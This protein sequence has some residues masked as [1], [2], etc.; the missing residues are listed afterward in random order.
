MDDENNGVRNN[1][2]TCRCRSDSDKWGSI[3]FDSSCTA[4][5]DNTHGRRHKGRGRAAPA[6]APASWSLQGGRRR[7]AENNR[8]GG[9][10][11]CASLC[12]H[13]QSNSH[14]KVCL[15]LR[16]VSAKRGEVVSLGFLRGGNSLHIP[17]ESYEARQLSVQ[18]LKSGNPE[19]KCRATWQSYSTSVQQGLGS[20]RAAA[21][22]SDLLC[23]SCWSSYAVPSRCPPPP[24]PPSSKP[25]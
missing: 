18:A 5:A 23:L 17:K 6:T 22:A 2:L 20:P 7:E 13:S 3:R 14:S 11:E 25:D 24:P 21:A 1:G 15:Q 19:K 12:V 16:R 10:E 4:A 9:R 8:G